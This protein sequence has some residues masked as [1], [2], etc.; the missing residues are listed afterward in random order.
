MKS[1]RNFQILVVMVA[2]LLLFATTTI[3]S[4]AQTF[5]TLYS[6]GGSDGNGPQDSLIQGFDGNFYGTTYSGGARNFGTVF[7][8]TPT[9]TLT[10]LYS[11]CVQTGC[12]DGKYPA[13]NLV[14]GIDGNLYGTTNY[15]GARNGGEVFKITP[16]GALTVLY[17]FCAEANCTDGQGPYTGVIQAGDGNFYGTTL[18]G[19]A[20]FVGSVYKITPGGA[21]T[22]LY[23]FCKLTGCPDGRTPNAGLVQAA[24]GN[25]YGST[26]VNGANGYGTI[27]K[28]TTAG[29][30][31]TLYNFCAVTGC[32][33]GKNPVGRL[34]QGTDGSLYGTAS[35]GVYNQGTVFKI[36][37]AGKLTTLYSFCPVTGC[38]DGSTPRAGVV[39]ATD[40]NFYGTTYSGGTHFAAGT[41][42]KLT[43]AGTLTTLYSFCALTS[44]TDGLSP[45]AG[46]VQGT[47]GS[48]Y[49]TTSGGGAN[50]DGTAYNLSVG[51]KA[52]VGTRPTA[53]KVGAKVIILGTNLT[54]ATN[55][56]FN[57][58][59]ATFTVVSGS[60]IKTTVP[61]GATT[62]KVK[63]TT[64][65]G[66]LVSNVVFRV[67][68]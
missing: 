50:H 21:L 53:G 27:F 13:A 36:T 52:F 57:G 9:G 68:P 10:M 29:V 28:I 41:A 64:S 43:P 2:L 48:F 62:G 35:G 56:S 23:S 14:V 66:T 67:K 4:P 47:D 42:F 55:V 17:N 54:G 16:A 31:T 58:T 3:A 1:L 38:V 26:S 51:L 11:F 24:D 12:T 37:T 8:I 39:Q 40:G 61:V 33:D 18:S 7:K 44:C 30:F 15:G 49:G 46:L 34:I 45:S 63:V 32:T 25:L 59:A 22:K 20:Y 19:G 6:F 65:Q 5:G 60:E